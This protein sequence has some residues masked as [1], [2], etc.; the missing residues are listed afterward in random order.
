MVRER[1]ASCVRYAVIEKRYFQNGEYRVSYGI[2][3]FATDAPNVAPTVVD[4]VYDITAD[5][6]KINAFVGLCNHGALSI[7]HFRDAVDDFLA[8]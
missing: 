3:A 8:E 1:N 5:K 6:E 4:A 7:V 2:A